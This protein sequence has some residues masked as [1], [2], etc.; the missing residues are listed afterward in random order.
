MI[1]AVKRHVHFYDRSM[2]AYPASA[3]RVILWK[4]QERA[5]IHN[6]PAVIPGSID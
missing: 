6:D 2:L 1:A 4:V 3:E 5:V